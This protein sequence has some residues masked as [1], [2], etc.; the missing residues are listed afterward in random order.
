[1]HLIADNRLETS[2]SPLPF[3]T[4]PTSYLACCIS[5]HPSQSYTFSIPLLRPT[6][7]HTLS[8]FLPPPSRCL[9]ASQTVPPA[10]NSLARQP[11]P[12]IY[13][14]L[15]SVGLI[16]LDSTS[17]LR[18]Y[19]YIYIYLQAPKQ[20]PNT[21]SP[22]DNQQR[23]EKNIEVNVTRHPRQLNSTATLRISLN[24]TAPTTDLPRWASSTAFKPRLSCFASSSVTHAAVI[25]A[26]PL[27][28]TQST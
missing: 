9:P 26:P 2:T 10:T 12:K 13:A 21:R 7:T 15:D 18:I 1:M 6:S 14:E 25:D 27:F 22:K 20:V 11:L 3:P 4:R 16:P 28:P 24:T 17:Q 23:A 8:S 19:I 5:F